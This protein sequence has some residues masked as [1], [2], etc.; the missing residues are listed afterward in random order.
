MRAAR[1]KRFVGVLLADLDRFKAVNDTF[2][3]FAGDAVLREFARRAT[4]TMRPYDSIGRYGGEEFLMVLPGCDPVCAVNQAERLRV[5]IESEPVSLED[6][7]YPL[8]CSFG[9][10]CWQPGMNVTAEYL[11]RVADEAL[12]VAKKQGRNRTVSSPATT[13]EEPAVL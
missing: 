6:T 3:H 2:G 5:A 1:E 13:P 11:I 8:T 4:A 12:Y 10:T 7:R 9:V